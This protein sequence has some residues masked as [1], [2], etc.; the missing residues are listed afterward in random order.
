LPASVELGAKRR[1]A[2]G[3]LIGG[4]RVGKG[5]LQPAAA[6]A[7]LSVQTLFVIAPAE[8][9]LEVAIATFEL[10][11]PELGATQQVCEA[12]VAVHICCK[13]C[14]RPPF[15]LGDPSHQRRSAGEQ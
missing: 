9:A 4:D 7:L 14:C 3:D 11:S 15:P 6:L 5:R 8:L 12:F 13:S 1:L 10:V 2:G